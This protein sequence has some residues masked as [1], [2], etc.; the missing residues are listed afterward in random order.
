[1]LFLSTK[2]KIISYGVYIYGISIVFRLSSMLYSIFITTFDIYTITLCISKQR[3]PFKSLS[4]TKTWRHYI[5]IKAQYIIMVA[6]T[7]S[8]ISRIMINEESI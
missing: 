8:S 1:M 6:Q 4:F 7:I 2:A 5:L 3:K